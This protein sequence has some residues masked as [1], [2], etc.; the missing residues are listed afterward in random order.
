[1]LVLAIEVLL[2]VV[3][4]L[5]ILSDAVTN[6]DRETFPL[7]NDVELL[8]KCLILATGEESDL[9]IKMGELLPATPLRTDIKGEDGSDLIPLFS[10]F[11]RAS[12]DEGGREIRPDGGGGSAVF[13]LT[14]ISSDEVLSIDGGG[15]NVGIV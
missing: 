9:F 1:V 12:T 10:C 13:V 3:V 11:L 8:D 7:S 14:P 2:V 4:L 15:I 5:F 6:G